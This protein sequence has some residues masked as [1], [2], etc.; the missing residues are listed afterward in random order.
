MQPRKWVKVSNVVLPNHIPS[1]EYEY[2]NH[3]ASTRFQE[4]TPRLPLSPKGHLVRY[5]HDVSRR[6]IPDERLYV[7]VSCMMVS[8]TI[9]WPLFVLSR[10]ALYRQ[11]PRGVE[12]TQKGD[13]HLSFNSSSLVK[14]YMTSGVGLF[15]VQ[16]STNINGKQSSSTL[17]H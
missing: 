13:S 3:M 15:R 14:R 9:N 11:Q 10:T 5:G 16:R 7:P 4:L 1:G 12:W 6:L 2:Q 17:S 8:F